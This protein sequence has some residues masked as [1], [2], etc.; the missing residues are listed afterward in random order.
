MPIYEFKCQD[1]GR[2]TSIFV[3]SMSTDYE[4]ACKHC[5]GKK[6]SRA[7]SGFAYH[8][9]EQTILQEYGE[10]PKRPE[11]YRD[12]RQIGR[13]VERRFREAGE[14]LPEQTRKMIDA[15]REGDLPEPLKDL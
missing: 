11:D 1:C 15:A 7:V 8:K 4:A 14:E 10:E 12:P 3:K 5:G 13:W 6:L 9:S 2:L